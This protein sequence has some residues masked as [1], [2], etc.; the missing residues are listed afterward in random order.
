MAGLPGLDAAG[1]PGRG[2]RS[3]VTCP[4]L[5][6]ERG[7]ATQGALALAPEM[8]M[9]SRRGSPRVPEA[10]RTR[11]ADGAL[12][13]ARTRPADDRAPKRW[14]ARVTRESR[15]LV[16]EDGVFTWDDPVRIARSLKHSAE[17]STARKAEPFASAMSM[18]AFFVN[19]AGRS[20]P[21]RRRRVL[22][23]AKRAL[24]KEFGRPRR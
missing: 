23:Q 18:L 2:H 21:A 17:T 13:A 10:A 15:A 1:T 3:R 7:Q 19:R 6:A 8:P 14:S 20:L 4:G 9:P 24:R 11:R 12:R 22:E 16:L 5:A